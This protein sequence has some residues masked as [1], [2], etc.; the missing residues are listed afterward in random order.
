MLTHHLQ[1][2]NG[3]GEA[4]LNSLSGKYGRFDQDASFGSE[5]HKQSKMERLEMEISRLMEKND[6]KLFIIKHEKGGYSRDDLKADYY[7]GDEL[8]G[9]YRIDAQGNIRERPIF[10]IK[11]KPRSTCLLHQEMISQPKKC[12][13]ED[14]SMAA[15]GE[16][17]CIN[18]NHAD[19]FKHENNYET[20]MQNHEEDEDLPKSF[21]VDQ[22][23]S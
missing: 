22:K 23:D 1:D 19:C 16:L 4:L 2:V 13:E 5:R 20:S 12:A 3:C 9:G 18:G 15:K 8:F 17:K 14:S 6:G 10:K 7:S 11:F 21:V